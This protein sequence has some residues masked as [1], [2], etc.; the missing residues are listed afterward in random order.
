MKSGSH[1]GEQMI[2]EDLRIVATQGKDNKIARLFVTK[3][4]KTEEPGDTS[5]AGSS[6]RQR[7]EAQN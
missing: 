6:G 2:Y 3:E 4:R 5:S 7:E 1:I